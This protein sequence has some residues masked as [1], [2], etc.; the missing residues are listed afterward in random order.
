M[1]A[2]LKISWQDGPPRFPLQALHRGQEY[3]FRGPFPVRKMANGDIK[4]TA[5]A[6]KLEDA[7]HDVKQLMAD[8]SWAVEKAQQAIAKITSK[9]TTDSQ[10]AAQ[11]E[12][13]ASRGGLHDVCRSLTASF[14][15]NS[16]G[17]WRHA[18][19][20]AGTDVQRAQNGQNVPLLLQKGSANS[21][22]SR[23]QYCMGDGGHRLTAPL[24][25]C[26]DTCAR[27]PP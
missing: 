26:A 23:I 17:P 3:C 25:A 18:R 15:S 2:H 8:V 16:P 11:T 1:G 13:V 21:L 19:A 24:C 20:S 4:M 6:T 5:Q 9:A 12:P 7:E 14:N 27:S 22:R 10:L